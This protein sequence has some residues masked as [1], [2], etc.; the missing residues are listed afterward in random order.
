MARVIRNPKMSDIQPG[1]KIR[2]ARAEYHLVK[3]GTLVTVYVKSTLD[4]DLLIYGQC[5]RV[6][7]NTG[8]RHVWEDEQYIELQDVLHVV[9][10]K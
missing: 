7:L 4:D 10:E 3:F 1:D 2:V 5:S 6:D 9:K 8:L